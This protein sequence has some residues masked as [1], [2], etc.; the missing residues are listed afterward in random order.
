MH[1]RVVRNVRCIASVLVLM[2][3]A[4]AGCGAKSKPAPEGLVPVTGVVTVD[5]KP[6]VGA[7]LMFIPLTSSTSGA[8][9]FDSGAVTDA[10]GAFV[11]QSGEG[12][13]AGASPG[14]Y[15]VVISRL[16]MS[17]GSIAVPTPEKSPM[18]LQLDGAKETVH[19]NYSDLAFS[20]LKVTVPAGGGKLDFKLT[21]TGE[22]PA[23]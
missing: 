8:K 18:Q 1:R 15:R 11:L 19:A 10:T 20:K 3:A 9:V 22:V 6:L 16:E 4:I 5:D 23:G 12:K 7:S 21:A 14:E 17:D 2:T 13:F